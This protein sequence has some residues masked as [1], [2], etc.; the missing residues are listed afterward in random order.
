M[1]ETFGRRGGGSGGGSGGGGGGGTT[2]SHMSNYD[3]GVSSAEVF[4]VELGA[5]E[6][7][8]V[9]RAEIRARGGGTPD[10]VSFDFYDTTAGEIL[11]STD[12]RETGNGDE[13]ARSTAGA[14]VVGRLTNQSGSAQD[15]APNYDVHIT[16]P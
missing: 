3:A 10:G 2:L 11:V 13:L 14:V 16:A 6:I 7:L 4:R 1:V 15:L 8:V 5:N 12:G 9:S